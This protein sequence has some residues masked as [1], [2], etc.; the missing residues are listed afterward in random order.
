MRDEAI[1]DAAFVRGLFDEMSGTYGIVNVVSSFGFCVRWR[2]QCVDGIAIAPDSTVCDLMSGTGELWPSIARRLSPA[3]RITAV[4][5]SPAMTT[6]AK[7]KAQGVKVPIEILM[8]DALSGVLPDDMADVIVCSFGLKTL[9]HEQ[10]R[11]LARE[12]AR[13]LK[14]G[15]R[16]SF[17]EISVPGSP[18]LSALYMFYVRRVIPLIGWLL[19]GNPEDYRLLGVYTEKFSNCDQFGRFCADA[20]LRVRPRSLF[21]GCATGVVGERLHA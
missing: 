1:Y 7:A 14:P 9:E 11:R 20:G 5:F 16:L 18:W 15:G 12:V 13:V 8:D 21:W 2:R 19:L 4:D 6:R 10:L 3:G 17:V